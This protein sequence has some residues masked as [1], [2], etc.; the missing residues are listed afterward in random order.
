M[1]GIDG[2]PLTKRGQSIFA[3]RLANPANKDSFEGC[4]LKDGDFG[5]WLSERAGNREEVYTGHGNLESSCTIL[6]KAGQLGACC[7]HLY[8]STLSL[9]NKEEMLEVCV[10]SQISYISEITETWWDSS[11]G[12]KAAV[13]GCRMVRRDTQGR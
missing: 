6:E 10:H 11:H 13:G 12:C 9:G 8:I 1:L 7:K 5:P 4:S 3:N 2:I